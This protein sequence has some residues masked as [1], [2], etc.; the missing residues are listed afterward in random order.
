MLLCEKR[1]KGVLKMEKIK[2]IDYVKEAAAEGKKVNE[3]IDYS[4]SG[5]ISLEVL[6]N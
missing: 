5:S 2:L 6:N 3:G 4:F 1:P